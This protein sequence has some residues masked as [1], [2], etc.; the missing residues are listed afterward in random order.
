MTLPRD[1]GHRPAGFLDHHDRQGKRS[2]L[3]PLPA[4]S[5]DERGRGRKSEYQ[6]WVMEAEKIL[7][8]SSFATYGG[9]LK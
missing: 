1:A 6:D 5:E 4:A 9:T 2:L 3:C 7:L 8:E